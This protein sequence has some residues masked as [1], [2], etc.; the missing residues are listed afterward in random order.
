MDLS[1]YT[2]IVCTKHL[3][4]KELLV[5]RVLDREEG[6]TQKQ[7]FFE[8]MKCDFKKAS[9][10]WTQLSRP[11][12]LIEG[13]D[14]VCLPVLWVQEEDRPVKDTLLIQVHFESSGFLGAEIIEVQFCQSSWRAYIFFLTVR[15]VL[16][17]LI[18][19]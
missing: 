11:V 18:W 16:G 1:R 15:T 12:I 13:G 10:F 2:R 7:D 6:L 5:G 17:G 19:L 14:E 8:Q 4:W 3:C 9:H